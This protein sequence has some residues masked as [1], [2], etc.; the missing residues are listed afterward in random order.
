MEGSSVP[1]CRICYDT[2]NEPA[3]PLFRPCRCRG[4]M[5]WVHVGCLAHWRAESQNPRSFFE[6][7]SCRFKYRFGKGRL[8]RF[9]LARLLGTRGAI[10]G[11]ALL[12]LACL[13]FVAGFVA[14]FASG[15]GW[16][17]IFSCFNVEHL[18]SGGV[19]TGLGSLVGWVLTAAGGGLG[20][21]WFM[22]DLGGGRRDD[23]AGQVLFALMVAVGLCVALSW[24]Y[25]RLEERA[26][27]TAR[28]AQQVVLDAH[29]D[30][31]VTYEHVD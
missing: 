20:G 6:C 27:S 25:E 17:E 10:H 1:T 18:V 22:G 26:R 31:G 4:T 11:L 19:A 12:A 23:K 29:A 3:D 7:D 21:G 15:A 30:E 9:A 28:M 24:I 5:A 14:K 16:A 2:A 13:V 8:D